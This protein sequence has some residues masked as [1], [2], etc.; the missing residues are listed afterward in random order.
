MKLKTAEK[1]V[2]Y[3]KVYVVLL[4]VMIITIFILH[5]SGAYNMSAFVA[6]DSI[7]GSAFGLAIFALFFVWAF[8]K[9]KVMNANRGKK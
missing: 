1:I 8:A 6:D 5:Y 4:A 7:P 2:E 3:T 9:K